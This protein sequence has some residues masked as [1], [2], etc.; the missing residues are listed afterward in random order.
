MELEDHGRTISVLDWHTQRVTVAL[1]RCIECRIISIHLA[2]M[3][4]ELAHAA[5]SAHLDLSGMTIV[6]GDHLVRGKLE[7]ANVPAEH[8]R[9]QFGLHVAEQDG[10]TNASEPN[11]AVQRVPP[12]DLRAGLEEVGKLDGDDTKDRIMLAVPLVSHSDSYYARTPIADEAFCSGIEDGLGAHGLG[13]SA[14][15]L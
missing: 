14:V 12:S 4:W 10:D 15:N 11:T 6:L 13:S 8:V 3:P 1:V 7:C 9:G 2:N 5:S